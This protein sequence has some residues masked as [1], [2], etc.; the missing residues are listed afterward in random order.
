LLLNTSSTMNWTLIFTILFT[1]S[2]VFA[3][4]GTEGASELLLLTDLASR[5]LVDK[6]SKRSDVLDTFTPPIPLPRAL[7]A[8]DITVP[9]ELK[10]F[11][12]V[13]R[14]QH[15]ESTDTVNPD[16]QSGTTVEKSGVG[17]TI[18]K[19][20]KKW[21]KIVEIAVPIA[22]GIP[23]LIILGITCFLCCSACKARRSNKA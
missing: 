18:K 12:L 19:V 8:S 10:R 11:L 17:D 14:R 13:H 22:V 3:S 9:N 7:S 4:Q 6:V 20:E 1:I 16:L 2:F 15:E 23:L 21:V 5:R